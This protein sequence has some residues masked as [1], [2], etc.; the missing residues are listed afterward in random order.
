MNSIKKNLGLWSLLLFLITGSVV[1]AEEGH[2]EEGHSEEGHSEE[3]HGQENRAEIVQLSS[4]E[5]DEFNIEVQVAGPGGIVKI[6]KL[7]GEVVVNENR[8]AHIG[9]RYA[10]IV[11]QVLVSEG[12][13]VLEDQVLAVVESNDSL[14]PYEIKTIIGGTV[15]GRH[16]TIGEAV[17][18]ESESFVIADLSDVWIDLTVYQR[19]LDF[20]KVGNR[21]T[22]R[23]GSGRN[24]DVGTISYVA[25]VV[26]EKTRTATARLVL[27]NKEGYW[28]PGMF[29]AG[30][31]TV[32]YYSARISVPS[33]AIQSYEGEDVVFVETHE[34]F[35]P[36]TVEIGHTGQGQVEILSGL[37]V[38]TRYVSSGGFTIKAEL[39]KS[40]FGD[41]HGH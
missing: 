5:L 41:G 39:G 40:S 24:S 26:D 10:G 7:P 8:L 13:M 6:R 23:S 12:D 36:Q 37:A 1:L 34:G 15:I 16:L 14:T 20:I 28:R 9:P 11:T 35:V 17:S 22:V 38:G 25:P 30:S 19:D 3:G 29:V 31:V 4:A 18:R 2:G 33:S 32:G 21:V 27:D